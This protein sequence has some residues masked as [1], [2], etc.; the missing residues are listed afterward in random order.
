MERAKKTK[1]VGWM[2][3][4]EGGVWKSFLL[5]V[6]IQSLCLVLD[7]VHMLLYA[8]GIHATWPDTLGRELTDEDMRT[9]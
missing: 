2:K 6:Y 5:V 4:G 7:G 1:Q 3:K 8:M 9:Y